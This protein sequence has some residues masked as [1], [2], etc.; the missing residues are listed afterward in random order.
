MYKRIQNLI[1]IIGLG[2]LVSACAVGRGVM[3][4]PVAA[5]ENP[6]A[7]PAVKLVAVTDERMFE[8]SPPRPDIPSLQSTE[9]YDNPDI[10]HRA[11]ARKRGGFG[12]ALG[13]IVLPEGRTVAIVVQEALEKALR[14]SGYRVLE[15]NAAEYAG[16]LALK[17]K[18]KEFW[19]W[20]NPGFAQVTATHRVRVE[21][22]GNWPLQDPAKDDGKLAKGDGKVVDTV[23]A[24]RQWR[25]AMTQG[26]DSLIEDL[27][28]KLKKPGG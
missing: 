14:E 1:L 17:A 20:F 2:L 6:A 12:A 23:I 26:V 27:K 7:G 19:A 3:D 13:D 25:E 8:V 9:D 18:V 21:L 16:A 15:K 28:G 5:G 11:V 22:D 24:T 10:V 4:L